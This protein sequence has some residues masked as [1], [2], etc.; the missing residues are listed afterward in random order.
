MYQPILVRCKDGTYFAP[1]LRLARRFPLGDDPRDPHVLKTWCFGMTERTSSCS[2]KFSHWEIALEVKR[3]SSVTAESDLRPR[4]RR[5][6]FG[7]VEKYHRTMQESSL[8]SVPRRCRQT[9]FLRGPGLS[10]TEFNAGSPI[11]ACF[12]DTTREKMPRINSRSLMLS[13]KPNG[14]SRLIPLSSAIGHFARQR[15]D[16]IQDSTVDVPSALRS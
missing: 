14:P 16:S 9:S 2:W 7:C 8:K 10:G 1:N 13:K 12:A 15:M 4:L 5:N 11:R 3:R 6:R